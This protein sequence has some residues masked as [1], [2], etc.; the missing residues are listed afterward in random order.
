MQYDLT[1]PSPK[2]P[3]PNPLTASLQSSEPS[4]LFFPPSTDVIVELPNPSSQVTRTYQRPRMIL[5]RLAQVLTEPLREPRTL[6]SIHSRSTHNS[7][8][9]HGPGTERT[10]LIRFGGPYLIS[11]FHERDTMVHV[12]LPSVDTLAMAQGLS[13]LLILA[14]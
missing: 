11:R 8:R 2:F 10:Q 14:A 5:P 7:F 9:G 6:G 1:L 3:S 12:V 4:L 13:Q